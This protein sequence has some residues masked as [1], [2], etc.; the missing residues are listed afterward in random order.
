MKTP[1]VLRLSSTITATVAVLWLSTSSYALDVDA[2]QV[3]ARQSSCLM[4]HSV[5]KEK[6]GPP[7]NDVAA[8]YRA[9]TDAVA[10]LVE[11]ITSGNDGHKV[12]KTDVVAEQVNLVQWILSL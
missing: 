4:C 6:V 7:F 2:A 12:V 9:D 5:D 10:L 3:L 8:K 1:G 11:H